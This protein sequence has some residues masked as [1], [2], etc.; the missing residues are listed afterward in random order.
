MRG[1][2]RVY[3]EEF[4]ERVR[5]MNRSRKK[6]AALGNIMMEASKSVCDKLVCEERE[7]IE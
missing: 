2:E 5:I 4:E 6:S 1:I 3:I 7:Y